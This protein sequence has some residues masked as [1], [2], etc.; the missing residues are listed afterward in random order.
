MEESCI[1]NRTRHRELT[2][3]VISTFQRIRANSMD[4]LVILAL[5]KSL[6]ISIVIMK[7]REIIPNK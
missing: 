4:D 1:G 3:S 7:L 2:K 6:Y 5:V